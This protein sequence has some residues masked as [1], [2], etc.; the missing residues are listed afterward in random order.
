MSLADN[1]NKIEVEI[2]SA[3]TEFNK[4]RTGNKAATT[5]FRKHLQNIK[6]L[7]QEC[8]TGA[9]SFVPGTE[10]TPVQDGSEVDDNDE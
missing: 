6:L 1:V 10:G 5:R 9:M 8:R 2:Q 4:M 3:R 7:A